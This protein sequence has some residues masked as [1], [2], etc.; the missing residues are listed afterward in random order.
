MA[1]ASHA[2][3]G[4]DVQ[5]AGMFRLETERTRFAQNHMAVAALGD[6]FRRYQPVVRAMVFIFT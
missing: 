5:P 2:H 4:V 3:D 6:V 1:R